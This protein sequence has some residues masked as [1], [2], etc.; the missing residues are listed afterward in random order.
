M[1]NLPSVEWAPFQLNEGVEEQ[2]LIMAADNIQNDFLANQPG[3]IKRE[4]LKASND[5]WVDLIYWTDSAA[6]ESAFQQAEHC[7]ACGEYFALMKSDQ[8]TVLGFSH[9]TQV[10]AWS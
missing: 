10:K 5:T 1:K 4:L 8:K 3:Y 2:Q 9:L 6:A 7:N